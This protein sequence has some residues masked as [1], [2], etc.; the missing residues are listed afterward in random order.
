MLM[1]LDPERKHQR[2]FE[3]WICGYL[4]RTIRRQAACPSINVDGAVGSVAS[5]RM[6]E[7]FTTLWGNSLIPAVKPHSQRFELFGNVQ[8]GCCLVLLSV[9][10]HLDANINGAVSS[11]MSL[12]AQ[13]N[14]FMCCVQI[15]GV[16]FG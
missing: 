15:A 10:V 13:Q 12:S 7:L 3:R 4:T 8:S 2:L 6:G 9:G 5:R 16:S 1:Q 14:D 11:S